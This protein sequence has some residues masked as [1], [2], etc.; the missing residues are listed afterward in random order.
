MF[1]K[2]KIFITYYFLRCCLNRVT[3][4]FAPRPQSTSFSYTYLC[5]FNFFL[6]ESS[7]KTRRLPASLSSSARTK[8]LEEK[9]LSWLLY[10]LY[11][12]RH[13]RGSRSLWTF[14]A[15][16]SKLTSEICTWDE[17]KG[18][19]LLEVKGPVLPWVL[20]YKM[21]VFGTLKTPRNGHRV[22]VCW[23]TSV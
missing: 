8:A 3:S 13:C 6:L 10:G 7:T 19:F 18:T 2:K 23:L 15:V 9:G 22:Y 5:R 11:M 1:K 12:Q 20:V 14:C 16:E 17:S 21:L 4:S